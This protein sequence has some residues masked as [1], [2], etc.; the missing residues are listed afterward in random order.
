MRLPGN[1]RSAAVTL[2]LGLILGVL[3]WRAGRLFV[4]RALRNLGPTLIAQAE[5]ALGKEIRVRRLDVT[6]PGRVL[7]EGLEVA[8]GPSFKSGVLLSARRVEVT[9]DPGLL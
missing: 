4:E 8:R 2:V 3:L 7:I 9:Y 1:R 6:T 5:Q